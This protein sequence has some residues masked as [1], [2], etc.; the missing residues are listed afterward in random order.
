MCRAC[1]CNILIAGTT[2][3]MKVFVTVGSTLFEKLVEAVTSTEVLQELAG[4]G[5]THLVIQYG[6]GAAPQPVSA[7]SIAISSYSL[8]PSIRENFQEADL[9]ISHAGAVRERRNRLQC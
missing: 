1:R 4:Q 8:K 7:S 5:C 6:K 9:V 2:G 3:R